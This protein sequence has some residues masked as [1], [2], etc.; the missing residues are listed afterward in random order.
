MAKAI[1]ISIET[2]PELDLNAR[3]VRHDDT[4]VARSKTTRNFMKTKGRRMQG[5][6]RTSESR[7]ALQTLEHFNLGD[8]QDLS[9]L[10]KRATSCRNAQGAVL[11]ELYADPCGNRTAFLFGN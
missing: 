1:S 3:I 9:A 10:E 4:A 8:R 2:S 6:P 7:N 11:E 5:K